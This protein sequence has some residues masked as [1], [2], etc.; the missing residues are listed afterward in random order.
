MP[1]LILVGDV[2]LMNLDD[3]TVPFRRVS[4]VFAG[5]DAIFGNLECLL[6]HPPEGHSVEQEGFFADPAIAGEALKLGGFC[7]VGLANNV[8]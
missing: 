4:D 7:A 5:A 3:P 6:Y 1:S 2:N 8:N